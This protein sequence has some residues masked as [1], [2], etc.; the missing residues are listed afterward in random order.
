MEVDSRIATIQLAID[1]KTEPKGNEAGLDVLTALPRPAGE[2]PIGLSVVSPR[3]RGYSGSMRII[4]ISDSH[5]SRD[6]P[7]RTAELESCIQHINAADPQ[8][9][10]VVHTGDVA[11]NGLAEEYLTARRLLDNLSAPYIV[12]AGNRDNRQEL[13]KIF[14]DVCRLQLGSPFIQYPV[15]EF[16]TRLICIDTV[17]DKSNKGRLCEARLKHIEDLLAADSSRPVVLLLHHPPFEVEVAPDPFQFEEWAD[18]DALQAL[19]KK[20]D[21]IRGLY[22]GHIHRE[23][24]ATVGLVPGH[25]ATCIASDLRWD[26]VT[27]CIYTHTVPSKA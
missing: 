9:D 2:L 16:D 4:Q 13:L 26:E 5:I 6:R 22:C 19:I 21:Q 23:A 8:P 11:H 7:T 24:E 1:L 14:A 3:N 18:V 10:I 12:L 20:H 15:E 27:N 25:V 17:S